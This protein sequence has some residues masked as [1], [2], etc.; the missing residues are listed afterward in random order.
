MGGGVAGTQKELP[1]IMSLAK[2]K[3][4]LNIFVVDDDSIN[5]FLDNR[6]FYDR[7]VFEA[8]Q[9]LEGSSK[10]FKIYYCDRS[11]VE[12]SRLFKFLHL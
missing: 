11:G 9:F 5:D 12:L 4:D 1:L 3:M 2:V 8:Q 7:V 6:C 10:L